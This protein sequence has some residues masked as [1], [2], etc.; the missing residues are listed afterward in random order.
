MADAILDGKANA[1]NELA[2]SVAASD[3]FVEVSEGA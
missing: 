1:T 2:Q 3:E